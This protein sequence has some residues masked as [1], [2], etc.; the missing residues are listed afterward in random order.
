MK[1]YRNAAAARRKRTSEFLANNKSKRSFKRTYNAPLAQRI[2]SV[3]N[4][5]SE[6]K[7]VQTYLS[8]TDMITQSFLLLNGAAEGDS[9]LTRDGKRITMNSLQLRVAV[10]SRPNATTNTP[11]F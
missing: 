11:G 10:T 3:I 2:K 9:E 4:A 7:E 6:K 1:T 8:Q 5:T